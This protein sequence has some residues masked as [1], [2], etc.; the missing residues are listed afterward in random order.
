MFLPRINA[1]L[2]LFCSAWDNH[3]I[4]IANNRTPNQLFIIGQLYDPNSNIPEIVT[5]SYGIDFEGPAS[6]E[7]SE[8]RID[9]VPVDD[10]LDETDLQQVLQEID[11]VAPSDSFG[12][13]IYIRTLKLVK[14]ILCTEE[15]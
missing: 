7:I 5:D 3:P 1:D 4:R 6:S 14:N 10:I 2:D 9:T 8:N 11:F 15:Q 12:I 13:D